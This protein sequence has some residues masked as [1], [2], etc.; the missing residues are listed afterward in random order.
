MPVITFLSDLLLKSKGAYYSKVG[1]LTQNFCQ[2]ADK[3]ATSELQR[4]LLFVSAA[5]A[6]E[7]IARILGLGPAAAK[8]GFRQRKKVKVRKLAVLSAM[9]AYLS[10]LLVLLGTRKDNVIAGTGLAEGEWM[11]KWQKVFDYSADDALFFN[12]ILL[13]EFQDGGL[14]GLAR[15]AGG[16]MV[17]M[18]CTDEAGLD[19]DETAVLQ[20]MLDADLTALLRN[21]SASRGE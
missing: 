17:Q 6:D 21:L 14:A 12:Q 10:A 15:A 11:N 9:R 20:E 7:A 3:H 2:R 13:P 18:L 5:S 4:R 19:E 16:Y 1:I 8:P